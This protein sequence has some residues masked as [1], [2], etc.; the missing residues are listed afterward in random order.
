MTELRRCEV[1]AIILLAGL[2]G[3]ALSSL[4]AAQEQP[5]AKKQD[6]NQLESGPEANPP[7]ADAGTPARRHTEPR[8]PSDAIPRSCRNQ[9]SS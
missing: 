9:Q 7:A 2:L 6:G 3:L 4:A 8:K 1:V 5:S